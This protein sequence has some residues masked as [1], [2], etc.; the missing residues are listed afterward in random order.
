MV[1]QLSP[2]TNYSLL[3]VLVETIQA[4]AIAKEYVIVKSRSKAGY[5]SNAIAKVDIICERDDKPQRKLEAKQKRIARIKCDCLF[6]V[7]VLYK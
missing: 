6:R 7:N 2:A 1:M 4:H 3:D 5:K